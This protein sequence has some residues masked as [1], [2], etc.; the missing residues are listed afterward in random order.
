[1]VH[2]SKTEEEG[3]DHT[4]KLFGLIRDSVDEYRYCFV[5]AVENMRN[6][7]LRTYAPN[8]AIAGQYLSNKTYHELPVVFILQLGAPLC[9]LIGVCMDGDFS[10]ARPKSWPKLSTTPEDEHAPTLSALSKHVTGTVGL[11]FTSREPQ[12]ILEYFSS[13]APLDY[14]RG[15]RCVEDVYGSCWDGAL[16]GGE[17]SAEE[18]V[19]LAHSLEVAVRKLGMP[20]KLVKGR[21]SWRMSIRCVGREVLNSSQ[22][23]LLKTFGVVTA[24]FRVDVKAYWS[25]AKREVTEIG[26]MEVEES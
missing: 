12:S 21:W 26:P 10:S 18:D 8:L 19:P 24:E 15:Y 17:I 13:Y 4:L 16:A 23:A 9:V 6:T 14:A 1:V 22:T 3:K 2:L 20:T 25:A 7:Y 11:L 5:F